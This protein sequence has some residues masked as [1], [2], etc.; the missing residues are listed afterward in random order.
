MEN[1]EALCVSKLLGKEYK[2]FHTSIQLKV[3]KSENGE[4]Q[5][6]LSHVLVDQNQK[7]EKTWYLCTQEE[8][9]IASLGRLRS[10]EQRFRGRWVLTK[11]LYI[12][13]ALLSI[14]W[15]YRVAQS[16]VYLKEEYSIRILAWMQVYSDP[17]TNMKS[18]R[19]KAI[20]KWKFLHM[21][22][23]LWS[24]SLLSEKV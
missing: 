22:D 20:G 17:T 8:L 2:N 6:S 14:E 10:R 5:V 1:G 13:P 23:S 3:Q 9:F 16:S 18:C 11:A 12:V 24:E 19:T 4:P 15:N 21:G 7:S